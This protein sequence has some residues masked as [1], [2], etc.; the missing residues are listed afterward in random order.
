MIAARRESRRG[1]IRLRLARL[2]RPLEGGV[3]QIVVAMAIFGLLAWGGCF[4]WQRLGTSVKEDARYRL[5]PEKIH[6]TQQPGWIR[7]NVRDEAFRDGGLGE[8][9]LLEPKLTVRVAQAFTMHPWVVKATRVSKDP[10]GVTVEL[11]YRRPV[12]MVQV[13]FDGEKGLLPV[14]A[15]G[16]LLPSGDF[17]TA[18]ALTYPRIAAGDVTPVG[19][20]GTPWGDGRVSGAARIAAELGDSWRR[21]DLSR[22]VVADATGQNRRGDNVEFD[23]ITKQH[24]RIPWGAAP[25]R[26]ASRRPS[27]A[28]K[29][30]RLIRYAERNRRS[31]GQGRP[32]PIDLRSAR[33]LP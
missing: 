23:L 16:V 18:E 15:R 10:G 5:D 8:L 28:E 27:A 24:A 21:L 30:V 11:V 20:V 4:A 19:P 3:R 17:T 29:T 22:I 2:A 9:S 6:I 1:T 25:G 13:N 14:D 31:D 12:A 26:E 33:P 32:L 7:A